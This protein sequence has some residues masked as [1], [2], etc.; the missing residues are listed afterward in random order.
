M[1]SSRATRP[2]GARRAWPGAGGHYGGTHHARPGLRPS[3]AS[4]TATAHRNP[5]PDVSWRARTLVMR[6]ILPWRHQSWDTETQRSSQQWKYPVTDNLMTWRCC[7]GRAQRRRPAWLQ[8]PRARAH[9]RARPRARTTAHRHVRSSTPRARSKAGTCRDTPTGLVGTRACFAGTASRLDRETRT[10]AVVAA[11]RSAAWSSR[12]AADAVPTGTSAIPPAQHRSRRLGPA[13]A[14]SACRARAA[15]QWR[16]RARYRAAPSASSV[17]RDELHH[18]RH[19]EPRLRHSVVPAR[20]DEV[21]RISYADYYYVEALCAPGS[22][23]P[24]STRG[25][26]TRHGLSAGRM[27]RACLAP[28]TSPVDVSFDCRVRDWRWR[29]RYCPEGYRAPDQDRAPRDLHP[30]RASLAAHPPTLRPR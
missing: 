13:I 5:H 6:S 8:G 17:A 11:R 24:T 26:P 12:T 19:V 10:R 9:L 28:R 15:D 22:A 23:T 25:S 3:T 30:V 1:Y 16:R 7:S 4:A 2:G 29:E 14:S 18:P 21:T 20:D 27:P